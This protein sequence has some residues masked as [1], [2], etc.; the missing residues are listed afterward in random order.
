MKTVQDVDEVRTGQVRSIVRALSI[1]RALAA[2]SDGL[3]LSETAERAGLA[4]STA[5][6]ILTTLESE[7]FVRFEQATG[8]W[9][10]GV[11]AFTVGSAFARN[12]DIVGMARPYLR[13]LMEVTGETANIYVESGGEVICMAQVESRHAMRAITQVGGRVKMHLSGAG[14]ALLSTMT[15]DHVLRIVGEHGLPRATPSTIVTPESLLRAVAD[16]RRRRFAHDDEEFTEGLRCIAVPLYN[17]TGRGIAALSISGPTARVTP[18][19]IPALEDILGQVADE[20]MRDYGGRA[21][22]QQLPAGRAQ[23]A[24]L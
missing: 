23:T 11:S 13:R 22:D 16:T 8:L 12:R 17:E 15:D 2:S 21:P 5:H 10:V 18:A 20:I 6:R 7:R 3:N 24:L 4:P 19:R 9:Q 14:K 1:L